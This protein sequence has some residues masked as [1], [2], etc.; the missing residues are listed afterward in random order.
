MQFL[1]IQPGASLVLGLSPCSSEILR[2]ISV[3]AKGII[4]KGISGKY[5]YQESNKLSVFI[6]LICFHIIRIYTDL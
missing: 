1:K 6:D 5:Y 4:I 2:N 3:K